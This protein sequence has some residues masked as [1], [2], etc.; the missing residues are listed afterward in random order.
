MSIE[1]GFKH[2]A[3]IHKFT[4]TG[5]DTDGAPSGTWAAVSGYDA[6]GCRWQPRS[7]GA[8]GADAGQGGRNQHLGGGQSS[9]DAFWFSVD[10]ES[11]LVAKRRLV[12]TGPGLS[13]VTFEIVTVENKAG[14]DDHIFVTGR[15]LLA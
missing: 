12:V 6:V 14:A 11:E 2:I 5:T 9:V 10:V 15:R 8:L 13:S 3:A 4:A 7:V 1:Y